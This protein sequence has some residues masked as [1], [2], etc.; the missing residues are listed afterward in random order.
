MPVT[1]NGTTGIS[2]N[3]LKRTP[4][5]LLDGVT[6]GAVATNI[7]DWVSRI[8]LMVTAYLSGT[9]HLLAQFGTGALPTYLT[10]GYL[11][12]ATNY[13]TTPGAAATSTAGFRFTSSAM[14]AN[15]NIE[16]TYVFYLNEDTYPTKWQ[17]TLGGYTGNG[18]GV[19]IGAGSV[20]VE[21]PITALRLTTINGTDLITGEAC[22][23]YE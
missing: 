16:A 1:I 17:G 14:P 21:S 7:P 20:S 8:T 11:T 23:I 6:V 9:S 3:Y 10:A 22:I 19:M 4:N 18:G 5:V 2:G 15:V 12:S 13:T